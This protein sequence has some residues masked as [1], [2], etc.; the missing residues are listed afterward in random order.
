M[1][2]HI[3]SH[4]DVMFPGSKFVKPGT[5]T[6]KSYGNGRAAWLVG[7]YK[8]TVNVADHDEV[9]ADEVALKDYAEGEGVLNALMAAGIV[10]APLRFVQ[11]GWVQIPVC[12]VLREVSA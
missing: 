6:V 8:L 4:S 12:R 10:S 2:K 11:S 1:K 5:I 9:N 3:E 7:N